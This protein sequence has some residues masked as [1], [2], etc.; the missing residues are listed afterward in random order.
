MKKYISFLFVMLL[1]LIIKCNAKTIAPVDITKMSITDLSNALDKG[2]LTSEQLVNL[3]LERIEAYNDQFNAINQ[4]NEHAIEQAKK[5]DEERA[6]GQ[7]RSALHGIPLLVKCNID[8]YGMPTT[9]GTK[10]L[11]DN[12][13]KENA[14]AVQKLIDAGAIILGSTNMSEL[15]FSARDSHSSYGYVKNVF[16]NQY[17]PYGSSGGSAVGVKAAFAAA[18]LG[19]DTN[20]SVRLPASAA[21]LVGIR[22]TF[23]LVSRSGVIPYDVNRDTVGII[24]NTV[25]DNALILSIIA[26][27]DQNDSVTSSAPG[28]S[29]NSK[30]FSLKDINIGIPTQY[31]KGS[32]NSGSVT[33]STDE[34]IYNIATKAIAN[35]EKA[36]ANII[37]LDNF[38]KSSNITIASSTQS[39]ITMCDGINS[40]LKGTTGTIRSFKD[41]VYSD[42]H[43]QT[44][45]SYLSGCGT[46]NKNIEEINSK[47]SV[48]REYVDN[49]FT[50]NKLDI[51]IYPTLKNTP[52]EYNSGKA[53][54]SPGSSLG[55]VIGYPSI[56]IPMGYDSNGFAYGLEFFSTKNSEELLYNIGIEF[57]K[58]NDNRVDT[59]PLTPPLYEVSSE[60]TELITKYEN[61][62]VLNSDNEKIIDW[63][64]DVKT[65]FK[66][67]NDY[68]NPTNEAEKLLQS[69]NDENIENIYSKKLDLFGDVDITRLF[70]YVL[71]GLITG[72]II[73]VFFNEFFERN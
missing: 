10:S 3:Y 34:E 26:G 33:S 21:G 56:T 19:T 5:L 53:N 29:L 41:L 50:E 6:N 36:G 32:G 59:S 20:S 1:F 73:V 40:Y 55:S 38:V 37:Y 18:A 13:P 30:S 23:G 39:G 69:Y 48:Y 24:S 14:F 9:G 63:L 46:G 16:N 7:V 57:E 25:S 49:Y 68:D 42:G 12:Y 22:P 60:V 65:Y 28:F 27:V 52:G 31:L 58:V 45:K 66:N 61:T 35:L 70:V 15:A 71:F 64:A 2:Y 67:Y 44:L 17:T 51:I 4:L 72:I 62:L 11:L 8:V 43:I 47:K 54:I